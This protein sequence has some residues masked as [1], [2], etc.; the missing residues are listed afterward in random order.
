MVAL[1]RFPQRFGILFPCF[2]FNHIAVEAQNGLLTLVVVQ[3]LP[4]FIGINRML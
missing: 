1:R 4:T 3:T 2:V